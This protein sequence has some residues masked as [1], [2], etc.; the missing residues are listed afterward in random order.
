MT[1]GTP[2][3]GKRNRVNHIMCRRCGHHSYHIQKKACSH[4]GYPAARIRKFRWQMKDTLT[5][6]RKL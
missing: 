3:M 4:C 5:K 6:E 2:S 1:K